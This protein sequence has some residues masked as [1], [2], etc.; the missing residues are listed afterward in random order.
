[1]I[2]EKVTEASTVQSPPAAGRNVDVDPWPEV[3]TMDEAVDRF[4]QHFDCDA[5]A[6]R[7]GPF[8]ED[9]SEMSGPINGV[10]SKVEISVSQ[11]RVT[12]SVVLVR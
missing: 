1:V 8:G 12:A 6:T 11:G 2:H 9:E 5:P 10:S 7:E 4:A 3:S